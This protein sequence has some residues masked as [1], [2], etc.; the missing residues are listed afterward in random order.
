MEILSL[1]VRITFYLI[2]NRQTQFRLRMRPKCLWLYSFGHSDCSRGL[3]DRIRVTDNQP[4]GSFWY[5]LLD[6]VVKKLYNVLACLG[7]NNIYYIF[8]LFIF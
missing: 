2:C 7:D 4:R 6:S 5:C 3:K 1:C 8:Y